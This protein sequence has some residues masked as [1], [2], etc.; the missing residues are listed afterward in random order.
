MCSKSPVYRGL[1]EPGSTTPDGIS[2][3]ASPAGC[4]AFSHLLGN[5]AA[6][7]LL[8]LKLSLD[9]ADFY[10]GVHPVTHE[11]LESLIV[12]DLSSNHPQL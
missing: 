12:G 2:G 5:R 3:E 11:L 7:S 6:K 10:G 8:T 9:V 1:E 4:G